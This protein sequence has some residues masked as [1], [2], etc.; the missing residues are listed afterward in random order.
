[1]QMWPPRAGRA[2]GRHVGGPAFPMHQLRK[3][4]AMRTAQNTQ[5]RTQRD[6]AGTG[7]SEVPPG[8][9]GSDKNWFE[10]LNRREIPW[11]GS[12][13]IKWPKDADRRPQVLRD[14]H[15][16]AMKRVS[17]NK[18]GND[19]IGQFWRFVNLGEDVGRLWPS[20]GLLADCAVVSAKT[21]SRQIRNYTALGIIRTSR[22]WMAGAAG[23]K[24]QSRVIEL[25]FPADLTKDDFKGRAFRPRAWTSYLPSKYSDTPGPNSQDEYSDHSSP[26]YPDTHGPRNGEWNGEGGASGP[27]A[28]CAASNIVDTGSGT[29]DA[30]ANDP[31]YDSSWFYESEQQELEAISGEHARQMHRLGPD[32]DAAEKVEA[33]LTRVTTEA[34]AKWQE[35]RDADMPF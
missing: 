6:E 25:S 32:D 27:Q 1:M 17:A 19:A 18:A 30:P 14:W 29:L 11:T 5:R 4:V 31:L 16:V 3:D 12:Q 9:H 34:R 2:P 8:D 22:K 15:A 35:L 23:E 13:P 7:Y 33:W 10:K 21:I 26:E 28:P 20:D 24:R